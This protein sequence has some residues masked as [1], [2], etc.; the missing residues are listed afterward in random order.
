MRRPGGSR[1]TGTLQERAA[2][3]VR[4]VPEPGGAV[5]AARQQALP[6]GAQAQPVDAPTMVGADPQ[7]RPAAPHPT[8]PAR[9]GRPGVRAARPGERGCAGPRPS[10]G[11]GLLGVDGSG[12]PAPPGLGVRDRGGARSGHCAS[13][14]ETPKGA[15]A[16]HPS[17]GAASGARAPPGAPGSGVPGRA[18][19]PASP[20]AHGVG[21]VRGARRS[22]R[23]PALHAP[24]GPEPRAPDG[25]G[26]TMRSG[27]APP[28]RPPPT[29]PLPPL[30]RAPAPPRAPASP[31][32]GVRARRAPLRA[33]GPPGVHAAS[34]AAL[35]PSAHDP[36]EQGRG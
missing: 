31:P 32:A 27:L 7:G 21:A 17:L 22:P 28:Q 14:M 9:K 33:P 16:A 36:D 23:S 24:S 19:A 1:A 18:G 35:A 2:L 8:G 11:A 5:L 34:P 4:G 30:G 15:S 26:G 13:R 3:A 29:C 25:R 10:R 20:R 12:S 6:I